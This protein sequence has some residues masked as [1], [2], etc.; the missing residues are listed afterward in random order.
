MNRYFN[1][2]PEAEFKERNHI[3][4]ARRGSPTNS[5]VRSSLLSENL[6]KAY[7][8]WTKKLTSSDQK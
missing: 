4:R 6:A 5:K 7:Y 8:P 2:E 1:K 3:A